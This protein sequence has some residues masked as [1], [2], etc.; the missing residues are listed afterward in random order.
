MA[1]IA[2][3]VLQKGQ[4]HT[5]WSGIPKGKMRRDNPPERLL[6][7]PDKEGSE[8]SDSFWFV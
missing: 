6:T 4:H 1:V 3:I 7:H 2:V 8:G 5:V